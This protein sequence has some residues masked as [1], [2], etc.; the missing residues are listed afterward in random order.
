MSLSSQ[1]EIL[2]FEEVE[3]SLAKKLTDDDLF[4]V[5]SCI[6]QT[7]KRLK[8]TGCTNITGRG[9]VP[10]QF[11]TALELL[12]LSLL[13]HHGGDSS[14]RESSRIC[15]ETVIPILES[16]ISVQGCSLKYIQF[17]Y[18]WIRTRS[19]RLVN[20]RNGYMVHLGRLSISCS[21]CNLVIR[22]RRHTSSVGI[23]FCCYSCLKP[24]CV[25]CNLLKACDECKKVY[26]PSCSTKSETCYHLNICYSCSQ[27]ESCDLAAF[28]IPLILSSIQIQSSK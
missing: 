28:V 20:F 12:D 18:E 3:K 11:S 1:W 6:K 24:I 13:E 7:V 9:L 27:K 23:Q 22:G 4:A 26:C 5:L 25:S 19:E 21:K 10:L 16:V 17:P 14:R 15:Q 2:D 8:L